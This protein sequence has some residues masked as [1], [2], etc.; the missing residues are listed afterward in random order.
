MRRKPRAFAPALKSR[1]AQCRERPSRVRRLASRL[2]NLTFA[3]ANQPQPRSLRHPNAAEV[4]QLR[5]LH[6][7]A[8]RRDD[9]QQHRHRL[10]GAMR[11]QLRQKPAALA[12]FAVA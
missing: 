6:A 2:V 3:P 9:P 4:V 7:R 5:R 12:N 11:R 8:I 10:V 1:R